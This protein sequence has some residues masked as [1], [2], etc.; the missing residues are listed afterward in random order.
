MATFGISIELVVRENSCIYAD[1]A[2]KT[3]V[4]LKI[5]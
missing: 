3:Y 5:F 1:T 4:K 2:L